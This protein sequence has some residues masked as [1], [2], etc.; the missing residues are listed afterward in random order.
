MINHYYR[1]LL[2]SLLYDHKIKIG[3]IIFIVLL[4][5]F[6]YTIYKNK[7]NKI[8]LNI[9]NKIQRKQLNNRKKCI[10]R[11]VEKQQK[12]REVKEKE[13]DDDDIDILSSIEIIK[14]ENLEKRKRNDFYHYLF[15]E[16][17]SFIH[18]LNP[19]SI[20]MMIHQELKNC[21]G[22]NAISTP[23]L[24]SPT[25]PTSPTYLTS[26]ASLTILSSSLKK[27]KNKE[28]SENNNKEEDHSSYTELLKCESNDSI[29]H[30]HHRTFSFRIKK[31]HKS[32]MKRDNSQSSISSTI[33]NESNESCLSVKSQPQ[34]L[35]H[36][37]RSNSSYSNV[38]LTKSN[39]GD[40]VNNSK[41]KQ[42]QQQQPE[43]HHSIH[44]SRH[45]SSSSSLRITTSF[46]INNSS[47]NVHH[48]IQSPIN[49]SSPLKISYSTSQTNLNIS[50][51]DIS[52]STSQKCD[53]K[54][55]SAHSNNYS[56]SNL[57][58]AQASTSSTTSPQ[59]N[60]NKYSHIYDSFHSI[61]DI[62]FGKNKNKEHSDS[63]SNL[64]HSSTLSLNDPITRSSTS[65]SINGNTSNNTNSRPRSSF[66][67]IIRQGFEMFR[68]DYSNQYIEE[69]LEIYRDENI[70]R[71]LKSKKGGATEDE[72]KHLKT[73]IYIPNEDDND[74]T[75]APIIEINH[76][77][78]DSSVQEQLSPSDVSTVSPDRIVS[79][80]DPNSILTLPSPISSD[81]YDEKSNVKHKGKGKGKG[82]EV[83][84][85]SEG[86][87][88]VDLLIDNIPIT[89]SIL[90]TTTNNVTCSICFEDFH[91]NEKVIMLEC[92][93]I[94]HRPCISD[95][96]KLKKDCPICRRDVIL[97]H[98]N[99]NKDKLSR[100]SSTSTNHSHLHRHI[101][102]T[103][104]FHL[105]S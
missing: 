79:T 37:Q 17:I 56:N 50:N 96:L 80:I 55:S 84:D 69:L 71:A 81:N 91:I 49:K 10:K 99:K 53:S 18:H 98:N 86:D 13:E 54:R 57:D 19:I 64:Q 77:S 4:I 5:F 61:K 104:S 76:L 25:S 27:H 105:L 34:R 75:S 39:S 58:I 59:T 100:S 44:H 22:E 73:I 28:K 78:K 20:Y 62:V 89:D 29:S 38:S 47:M 36:H 46:P 87:H 67:D 66:F 3:I 102:K 35:H 11:K 90:H 40:I 60:V 15:N 33:S 32:S 97:N 68:D 74:E 24:I 1:Y 12:R 95:W 88:D 31:N 48:S 101:S 82:K 85:D 63:R 14:R 93:H 65:S 103:N 7:K 42:K 2:L 72:L 70:T 8:V 45:N 43:K 52:A 9:K 41:Q 6:K 23:S 83:V 21:N 26:S 16:S 94:F 92:S 51:D 30:K